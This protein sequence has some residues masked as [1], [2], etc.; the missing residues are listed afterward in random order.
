V[1]AGLKAWYQSLSH[2]WKATIRTALQT[3]LGALS[4]V[5]V[6]L[7][8]SLTNI[9][10]GQDVDLVQDL[11]NAGRAAALVLLGLASSV[12]AFIMNRAKGDSDELPPPDPPDDVL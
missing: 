12:W 1:I 3:M 5:V 4:L 8:A 9:V 6:A 11:S 10:S 7:I 2:Q